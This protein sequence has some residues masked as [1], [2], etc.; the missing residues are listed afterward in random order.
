M[1]PRSKKKVLS[2][3]ELEGLKDERKEAT[4][5]LAEAEQYGVGT[6][7]EQIDKAKV[8]AEIAHYDQEI[9]DGS[10]KKL[11]AKTKDSLVREERELEE[12]FKRGMPTRYEMDHPGRCPGAVRK[13]MSWLNNNEKP[14]FI[15]RYVQI[16]RSLRP[17]EEKSVEELRKDR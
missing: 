10:P 2:V 14:G 6:P 9:Q 12:Q 3:N 16:Q 13:H 11:V 15:S 1:G 7:G 8:A 4:I 5:V 17:G